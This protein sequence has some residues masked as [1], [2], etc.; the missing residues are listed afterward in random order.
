MNAKSRD[1]KFIKIVV[2]LWGP[3]FGSLL[4]VYL[5]SEGD[6]YRAY[7][8]MKWYN[9]ETEAIVHLQLVLEAKG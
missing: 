4:H 5:L 7:V 8:P 9:R 6:T 1:S 2:C 3:C